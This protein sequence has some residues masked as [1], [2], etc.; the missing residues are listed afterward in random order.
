VDLDVETTTLISDRNKGLQAADD[1]LGYVK[2]A[3]CT[4]HIAAN[5]QAK[6]GIEPRRKFVAVTYA[7]TEE[8]WDKAM[9]TLR[10][11]HSGAFMYVTGIDHTLWAAP[12]M[13]AKRWRHMASNIVES[14]N[15][16]LKPDRSLSIIDL[17]EAIWNRTVE[18]AQRQ[19][20]R[21][22]ESCDIQVYEAVKNKNYKTS[23]LLI[24]AAVGQ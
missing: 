8:Q 10:E 11:P 22:R 19:R 6:F 24:P 9:D 21:E 7:R 4:Q 16:T 5:V 1:K 15:A 2:R 17:L 3:L 18:I 13:E 20:E 23:T 14:V 12:F